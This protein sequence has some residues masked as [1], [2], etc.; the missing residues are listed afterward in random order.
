M[1][2][3][4][5]AAGGNKEAGG[6]STTTIKKEP[7]RVPDH[8]KA[9]DAATQKKL[10]K[11]LVKQHIPQ[12]TSAQRKVRLF[13]HLHQYEREVSLTQ[14]LAF[15][16]SGIH[17]AV[18]KL[19]IQYA[20]GIISGS[21]ARCLALLATFKRVI[22]DYSTPPQK[23]LSRD[24]EAKIKPYIS[25]LNQCRLLSVSMGNAIKYLK[26]N[27]THIPSDISDSEAKAMLYEGIDGYIQE[28]II[29]AADAISDH[30]KAEKKIINGDV[31]VVFACSSVVRKVL[32]D[33]YKQGI[34][35]RV[36]VVDGRPRMEGRE[37][38]RRLVRSGI[39]CTYVLM[40]AASYVMQEATK[41]FLGAHAML[42]NGWVM[43]RVGTSLIALIAKS[44][45]VPV[46]VCCETYKFWERGQTDSFVFN[47]LGD[48]D[49]VVNI[50]NKSPYLQ[51]WRTFNSLTLLN[52]VYD[53]TPP[54]FVSLVITELGLIPCTSVPVVLRMKQEKL[55]KLDKQFYE[56]RKLQY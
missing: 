1:K 6:A 9:D 38:L 41:V 16:S 21:N 43:S 52:L 8:L 14:S 50:G 48:P 37:M 5:G 32:L 39:K 11:K 4:S 55:M 13:N 23:E 2:A 53:V 46:L 28:K 22:A 45:S 49:D 36:I 42:N 12:R 34:Q 31:I 7:V 56:E 44:Y 3:E 29:L 26:W 24:L 47:E 15:S 25:F 35:F 40:N 19:G 20:E 17:P 10:T 51:D 18:I 27:I 33:A 54:E 30:V